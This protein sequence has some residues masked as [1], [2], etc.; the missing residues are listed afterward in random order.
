[1]LQQFRLRY[2][3]GSLSSD[4]V[5]IDRGQYIVRSQIV[6][7]GITLATGLAAAAT[8][9][10]AED[11]A[12]NRALALLNLESSPVVTAETILSRPTPTPPIPFS[13]GE[14]DWIK[15]TSVVDRPAA[16]ATDEARAIAEP[17]F[18]APVTPDP[19]YVPFADDPPFSVE[20]DEIE[21]PAFDFSPEPPKVSLDDYEGT[22]GSLF[23]APTSNYSSELEP[24]LE[25]MPTANAPIDF[26][27]VNAKIG[28]E[29]KASNWTQEQ[30]RKYLE[31]TYNKR[32]RHLLSDPELLDFLHFLDA[33][34]QST[35]EIKRLGWT[36]E[37]GR[38]YLVEHYGVKSRQQ[39]TPDQLLDFL[40][41]LKS[42]A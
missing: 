23:S 41:Y 28:V 1:M 9:E 7:E 32:Q 6:V 13:T 8:L 12:R 2:P 24:Y 19:S 4:L 30:E 37:Q 27:E 14:R 17:T 18:S 36:S 25:E 21:T 15:P 10:Q 3:Q 31:Q 33:F 42:Q 20:P 22:T 29:L 34:A 40:N 5:S 16:V 35:V 39:L 26:S 38:N 11:Q